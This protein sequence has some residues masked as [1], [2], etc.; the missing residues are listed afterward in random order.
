MAQSSTPFQPYTSAHCNIQGPGDARPTALE[1][2]QDCDAFDKLRDKNILITGCSGGLGAETARALYETGANL[3]L[4]ARDIPKL[5]SVVQDIITNRKFNSV[6]QLPPPQEIEMHLDSTQSIRQAAQDV[7]AKTNNSLDVLILNAGI[8]AGPLQYTR[9]GFEKQIAVNHL[10]GF[11]LFELVQPAL[12]KAAR[13]SGRASRVIVLSSAAHAWSPV[14]FHD[15]NWTR[16]P[17]TYNQWQAYGSSKTANIYTAS[18][19]DR[20]FKPHIRAWSVHPGGIQ[21]ELARSLR[22]ED[23]QGFGDVATIFRHYKSVEQ[24]AATTVWAALSLE[25]ETR[26]GGRYLADC[27]EARPWQESDRVDG[28]GYAEHAYDEEA[29]ELLWKRSCELL[30]VAYEG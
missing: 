7:L 26:S 19:I 10:A 5:S 13:D 3:F 21:T 1:I 18:A 12:L 9:D 25:L 16:F 29:E 30:G 2:V 4:T 22:E 28:S 27:G 6:K 15:L 8:M 11:L 24:G 20:K 23:F 17:M 14:R